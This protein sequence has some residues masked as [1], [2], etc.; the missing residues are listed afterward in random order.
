[1]ILSMP[2]PIKK[3]PKQKIKSKCS[4]EPEV[5]NI[6]TKK[7]YW[8][9]LAGVLAVASATLAVLM[10]LD[11]VRT[12]I[13]VVTILVPIGVYG[14]IRVTPSNLSLSKRLTFLFIGASVIGFSIWAA[15]VLIGGT[16]GLTA[17]LMGALGSQ[18]FI[19]TSLVIC[20]STGIFMGELIGK[21]KSVQQHI[22][23]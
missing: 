15:I 10:G 20:L 1:M 9:V 12:A 5:P 16:Y 2:K 11:T 3:K 8:V 14:Y 17:M 4:V 23:N 6:T 19:T 7:A 21:N 13:L 18:F 22:F